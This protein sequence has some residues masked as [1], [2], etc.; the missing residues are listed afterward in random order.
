MLRE[1][2]MIV[3]I[4]ASFLLVT[5]SFNGWEG[6]GSFGPRHILPAVPLLALPIAFVRGRFFV[7][8]TIVLAIVSAAI[9]FVATAVNPTPPGGILQPV[10]K[11]Y[12]PVFLT[13]RVPAD[14]EPFAA[15]KQEQHVGKV[16]VNRQGMDELVPHS[17]HPSGSRQ[18]EWAAFNAGEFLFGAGNRTSVLPIALWMIAGTALLVRA[19]RHA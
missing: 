1:V 2:V 13:G 17:Q 12:L 14:A 6:G 15:V 4:L 3:V 19:V 9:Q 5:A 8:I 11:Y 18:S 10:R 16:S 7:A